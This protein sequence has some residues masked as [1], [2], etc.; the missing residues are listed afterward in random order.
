MAQIDLDDLPPKAAKLLAALR[1]GD[2]LMLVQGGGVVGRLT[3]ASEVAPTPGEILEDL[4]PEERM[5]EVMSQFN[6]MIHDEF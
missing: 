3:V 2:E 4:P 1:E 5:E 6:A